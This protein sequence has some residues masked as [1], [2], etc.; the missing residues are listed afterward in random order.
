MKSYFILKK[1]GLGE[2]YKKC[3]GVKIR[4]IYRVYLCENTCDYNRCKRCHELEDKIPIQEDVTEVVLGTDVLHN[5][6]ERTLLSGELRRGS[7]M[8]F[9]LSSDDAFED[10]G[11]TNLI[12]KN[13]NICCYLEEPAI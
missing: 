13:Q 3:S 6:I 5:F 4:F 8:T 11:V 12:P 2:F 1:S 7:A 9:V 10:I